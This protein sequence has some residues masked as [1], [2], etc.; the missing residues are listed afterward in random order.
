MDNANK[1][2]KE[3][4]DFLLENPNADE[5]DKHCKLVDILEEYD[6]EVSELF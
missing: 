6:I 1:A 2:L 3:F 4:I 5:T